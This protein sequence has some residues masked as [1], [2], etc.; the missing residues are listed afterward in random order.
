LTNRRAKHKLL[1]V[2]IHTLSHIFSRS[3]GMLA[4]LLWSLPPGVLKW[5]FYRGLPAENPKLP[6]KIIKINH[7]LVPIDNYVYTNRDSPKI[8]I[9]HSKFSILNLNENSRNFRSKTLTL[10]NK[11]Q[12]LKNFLSLSITRSYEQ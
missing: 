5:L 3:R 6:P 7:I 4:H 1:T 2:S 11:N 9:L 10:K 12:N 8:T